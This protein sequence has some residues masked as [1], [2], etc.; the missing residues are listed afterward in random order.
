MVRK[1]RLS[2]PKNHERKRKKASTGRPKKK[3]IGRKKCQ[4]ECSLD[5]LH[6][7]LTFAAETQWID[8]SSISDGNISIYKIL[9]QGDNSQES[10]IV[11]H[12]LVVKADLSWTLT[13]HGKLVN[14]SNCSHLSSIPAKLSAESLANLIAVVDRCSICPGHPDENFLKMLEDK[15]GKLMS[16]NQGEISTIDNHSPVQMNGRT[17]SKTVRHSKC[18]MLVSEGKCST[19][20]KYRNS[21][22]RIYHRWSKKKL[23]PR[24]REGTNSHTNFRHL[25]TP[26]KR[27]RYRNLRRRLLST[28]KEVEK[29]KQVIEASNEK[30]GVKVGESVHADLSNIMEE[31]SGEILEKYPVGSFRRVFWEQQLEAVRK[32]DRRQIRWHPAIIKW[33]LHLKFISSGAY[34]ALRSSLLVLPSER[35]LRDYTHVLKRGVGF[36]PDV[37]AQLVSEADIHEDKDRYVVLMWDEMKIKEDLVFDKHTCELIGFANAGEINNHLDSFKRQCNNPTQNGHPNVA[38]HMLMFVAR[39]IFTSLEF[40]YAQFP[41]RDASA[42]T[43]FPIVWDAVAQLERA[44]LKVVAFACDGA[45]ANRKFYRMHGGEGVYKTPN[46]YS[47]EERDIYFFADIPHLMKTTRNCWSNS[48]AHRYTR[49]LWVSYS[50]SSQFYMYM[51]CG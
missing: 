20:V 14:P 15:K 48:F 26:E 13:V 18:Q 34:H 32:K 28:E 27:R 7:S 21:L 4:E 50:S 30:H 6:E 12:S 3:I 46:P 9:N 22:R 5:S 1:F 51:Q 42:D 45:S 31:M 47:D 8:H 24:R 49:C 36:L 23:S 41:T 35:T 19:C 43:L 2:A 39:G 25:N 11:T 37:T 16:K 38:T 33:C 10:L 29:L 44:G 17:F 40:P